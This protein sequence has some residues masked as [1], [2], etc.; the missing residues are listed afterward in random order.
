MKT[1]TTVTGQLIVEAV[2]AIQ[3]ILEVLKDADQKDSILR[4]CIALNAPKYR[5]QFSCDPKPF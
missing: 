5:S 2:S 3:G 4:A 1:E